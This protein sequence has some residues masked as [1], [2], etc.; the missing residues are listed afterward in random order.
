MVGQGSGSGG[1]GVAAQV[2]PGARATATGFAVAAR[3]PG[4]GRELRPGSRWRRAIVGGGTRARD[5]WNTIGPLGQGP[6]IAFGQAGGGFAGAGGRQ[7]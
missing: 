7:G 6:A 2:P 5:R 4:Q 1:Q 3:T